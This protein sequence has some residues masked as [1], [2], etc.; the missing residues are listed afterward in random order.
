[1][2]GGWKFTESQ[3]FH[4]MVGVA[5]SGSQGKHEPRDVTRHAS[6]LRARSQFMTTSV[7]DVTV[8]TYIICCERTSQQT[9]HR[10]R[11]Y[12]CCYQDLLGLPSSFQRTKLCTASCDE[13]QGTTKACIIYIPLSLRTVIR[14]QTLRVF[15]HWTHKSM[16]R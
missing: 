10:E 12:A 3:I 14:N 1:M 15:C 16:A 9:G 5:L 2:N 7:P 6:S 11:R 8:G 4:F 13:V